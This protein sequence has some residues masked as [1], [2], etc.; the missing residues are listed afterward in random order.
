M[1]YVAAQ[2][3]LDGA[4]LEAI[5]RKHVTPP[6]VRRAVSPSALPMA[7]KTRVEFNSDS[8]Q[9]GDAEAH[10]D[11]EAF[12]ASAA[13]K[14]AAALAMATSVV[15]AGS[16]IEATPSTNTL[17]IDT[18]T[19]NTNTTTNTTVTTQQDLLPLSSLHFT[20]DTFASFLLSSDNSVF[21]DQNGKV[22]QDMNRPLSE[23]YISS[24]HNT[25]LVGHQLV[26]VSTIEGYIRA[27]LQSCRSVE[28]ESTFIRV[29]FY[30]VH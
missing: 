8:S 17:N 7:A 27:L 4:G 20:L 29:C 23:Y 16:T 3:T 26:G 21:A 2:S 12:G 25:Y 11:E 30:V 15:P 14:G 6:V 5:F 18:N 28:S 10:P 13:L 19:N 24:S 1:Y 22:W 9:D